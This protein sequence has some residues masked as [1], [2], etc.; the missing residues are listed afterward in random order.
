VSFNPALPKPYSEDWR[1]NY[2][3]KYNDDSR[4]YEDAQ[5]P[6]R[7]TYQA[8]EGEPVPFV[9]DSLR[10]SGGQSVD[11]AEYPFFG[12]WSNTPLNE[13][14][15]TMT[16]NGFVRGDLYIKNRNALIEAFRVTTD[17]SHPGFLD[18]PLWGRFPVVVI[19]WDVEE[20]GK[21]NG[22]SS[23]SL[24]LT[25]AG[26]TVEERWKFEGTIEGRLELARGELADAA[27]EQFNNEL[28]NA[29]DP[30][31]L[32]S[33]FDQFKKDLIGVIGRVQG[34][35]STLNAM[36]NEAVSI[37]NLTAQGVRVPR[38]LAQALFSAAGSIAAGVMDIKNSILA[39]V[40]F[41]GTRDNAANALLQFLSR[42]SYRLDAGA[43]TVKQMT[44][45][46]AAENLYRAMSLCTAAGLLAQLES[47]TYQQAQTYWAL[48][49]NL[50]AAV[51]QSDPALYTS[52][53]DLRIAAAG[54]L[55]ARGLDGEL[56]RGIRLPSPLL[57]L[58]HVLGCD[59]ETFRRLNRPADSFV[60]KGEVRYV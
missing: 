51:D 33:A 6:L 32:V 50:E 2:G 12:L 8:P 26:V 48:Y 47:P 1:E 14:P 7:S 28:E 9:F 42:A 30:D 46:T 40:S 13:Q 10:L 16:V 18:L 52:I 15:H 41:F 24:T 38:D 44:T 43:V 22:Q 60:M 55:A 57:Y 59:A 56:V 37:T 17:D 31:T 27:I 45:K 39:T 25:R 23:V 5:D 20:R 36:T 4:H 29:V 35:A 21:E 34:A 3:L 19:S 54:E 58:A 49:E 11:T 53:R